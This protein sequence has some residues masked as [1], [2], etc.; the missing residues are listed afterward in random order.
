MINDFS[1]VGMVSP[2][3][4][5]AVWGVIGN[6]D[7]VWEDDEY[8]RKYYHLTEED[9]DLDFEEFAKK[10]GLNYIVS[11]DQIGHGHNTEVFFL[12]QKSIIN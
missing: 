1:E 6:D 9:D 5:V 7:I 2:C 11:S 10:V 4:H 8:Q 12:L 3:E